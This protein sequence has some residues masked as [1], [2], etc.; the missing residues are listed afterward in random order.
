MVI[1]LLFLPNAPYLITNLMHLPYTKVSKQSWI[2][3]YYHRLD[4]N[5]LVLHLLVNCVASH[6]REYN[7]QQKILLFHYLG[8]PL[9]LLQM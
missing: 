6:L 2:D 9:L 8:L 4:L 5:V 3:R 1:W 7:F